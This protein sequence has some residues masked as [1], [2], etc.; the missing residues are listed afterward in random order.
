[1]SEW[2][3]QDCRRWSGTICCAGCLRMNPAD[4]RWMSR[5][6]IE[7]ERAKVLGASRG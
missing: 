6:E 4:V 5:Y 1:M 2:Y 3:C 7:R